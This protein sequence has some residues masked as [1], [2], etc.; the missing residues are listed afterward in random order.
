MSLVCLLS[1]HANGACA[2]KPHHPP[3]TRLDAVGLR[4]PTRNLEFLEMSG[5]LRPDDEEIFRL[6][7]VE[8]AAGATPCL[9]EYPYPLNKVEY[10]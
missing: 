7:L 10:R 3:S 8:E 5:R 2:R 1:P 9:P 4:R 6:Q